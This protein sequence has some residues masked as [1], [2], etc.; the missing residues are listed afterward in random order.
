MSAELPRPGVEVIQ[1][2]RSVSPTVVTPTLSPC[3]VGLCRQIVDVLTPTAAGGTTL[4][5]DALVPLHAGFFAKAGVGT[6]PVYAGLDGLKLVV[7]INH[8]PDLTI[9]FVGTPLSPRQ[10]VAQVLAALAAAGITTATAELAGTTRWRLRT[11]AA[12]DYQTVRIVGGVGGSDPA[13][14]AAFGVGAE[15]TYTGA[16]AFSQSSLVVNT[17]AFPDPRHNLSQLA[18]EQPSVRAFLYMGGTNG[19]L[20]E[21]RRDRAFLRNAIATASVK[22]GTADLSA[23]AYGGS[24]DVDG[25]TF[26]VTID[27]GLPLTVTFAVPANLA[28]MLAQINAVIGA[29]ATATAGASNHLV[30]TTTSTG[31]DASIVIGAGT[32]NTHLGVTAGTTVGVTALKAIDSGTGSTVTSLIQAPGADF[33]QAAAAAVVTG[34][35]S[36]V[37]GVADGLTLIVDDGSGPQTVS[38]L[39]ATNE[40]TT[41]VQ[42]NALFGSGASGKIM[43]TANG[44]HFLVLTHSLLG[45]ESVIKIVGGTALTTL[46][47][48]VGTTRGRAYPPRSGDELY[49][50][51]ALLGIITQVAPAAVVTNLKIDKQIPI[52]A[53]LGSSYYIIAK[54]LPATSRPTPNLA[55]DVSGNVSIKND[56]IRD[57]QG[58]PVS[59]ANAQ[60]Y[61]AYHAVRQD[62]SVLAKSPALLRFNDT[63]A[64]TSQLS[65]VNADNPL[66]L[67]LYF[68]LLN[69]PGVQVMGLGVD[70]DSAA[71]PFGTVEAYARAAT[72]LEGFDVYAIAPLT[73]DVGVGQLFDA[74]VTAMSAPEQKGERI[75]LF[76]PS[77]PSAKRDTLIGSGLNG[78]STTTS[79][80]FDTGI[81]DLGALLLAKGVDPVGSLLV[82]DGV[83]LDVGDGNKY[84]I[85]SITGSFV[86]VKTTSFAPGDNDDG[87]FA[88]TTLPGTLIAQPFA[89]RIRGAA[90]VLLDG[91]PDKDGIAQT[92]QAMAQSY[93]NRRVWHVLP[94]QCAATLNGIEQVID[95]FYL[96]AAI[97]GLIG[98]QPPQQSFTNFPMTGFTRAIGSNDYLSEKQLNIAAAGGNYI[99]AQDAQG[100]PLF[101]RMALTTDMTSIETR[102][103][104]ITKIVD[105]TAKFMRRGLRN[106]IG[107]FNIT[108]GFLDSLGHVI[109]GLGGFLV[110]S[111]MLIGFNLNNIIQDASAPDT[112]LVD[113][114]LDVPFPCNYI[115]LTLVV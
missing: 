65:P 70:A 83:Y 8:G 47:L 54:S 14:L 10:V 85:T 43:A 87:Y 41:L 59:G 48:T 17:S 79:N 11:V 95:G 4:N 55:L 71:A 12:N 64:L 42:I 29:V 7:S 23:L 72:F 88:I 53:D 109:Q 108:Q 19:T 33:T 82:T 107:R 101:A 22:T 89:V 25:E 60:I 73:H 98:K 75:V 36:I 34:T 15:K 20:T 52:S 9:T 91:T 58:N 63:L 90:L 24:A 106:F 110:D 81:A 31:P 93:Q 66:A 6:P 102:T 97:A 28:A 3:C 13:V 39:T 114:T 105:F 51:G 99:V 69:A 35:A 61:L 21:V 111:G 67:G 84:A 103:D 27:D 18:I 86:T 113:C 104:S 26:I 45:Q 5:N 1:V 115:R 62:V 74:H 49:V 57:T 44:S 56:L 2:F 112:V 76:N 16:S 32:A 78:N 37:G 100:T 68:A 46:G 38:F 96:S 94:D 80:Q 77:A 50:D 30:I 92:Y 40:A